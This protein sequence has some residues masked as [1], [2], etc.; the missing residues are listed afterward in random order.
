V[1]LGMANKVALG[2]FNFLCTKKT[3][4]HFLNAKNGLFCEASIKNMFQ[5]R[6]T[7]NLNHIIPYFMHNSS[8]FCMEKVI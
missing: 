4:F 8:L 5:K 6:T 3:I 7:T 1:H 2:S